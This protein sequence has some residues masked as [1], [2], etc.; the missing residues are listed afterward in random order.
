MSSVDNSLFVQRD[1]YGID[2]TTIYVDGIIITY[3]NHEEIINVKF[4]L[5]KH[6]DI[7]DLGKL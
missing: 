2:I 5:R 7:K 4:I 3:N 1:S 6:F